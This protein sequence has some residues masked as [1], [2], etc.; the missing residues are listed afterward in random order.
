MPTTIC[1][2]MLICTIGL[3]CPIWKYF[4]SK[5]DICLAER[6]VVCLYRRLYFYILYLYI[7]DKDK[8]KFVL[9]LS[10][11]PRALA[12]LLQTQKISFL[13]WWQIQLEY[14]VWGKK[15]KKTKDELKEWVLTF[16]TVKNWILW[17]IN[18]S[19]IWKSWSFIGISF[20]RV[21]QLPG[22]S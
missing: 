9:E 5:D 14:K 7:K 4:F 2:D 17:K 12:A 22:L 1:Q 6:K 18:R 15:G 19:K 20:A 16:I 13:I 8:G 10:S 11:R 3:N 21:F